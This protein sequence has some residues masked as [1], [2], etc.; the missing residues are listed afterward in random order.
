MRIAVILAVVL[1]PA[2]SGCFADHGP[3][4]S[5]RDCPD[6][7]PLQNGFRV[8]VPATVGEGQ[9]EASTR[10]L[11]VRMSDGTPQTDLE[12]KVGDDQVA[13][14]PVPEPGHYWFSLYVTEPQDR[15]CAH[16]LEGEGNHTGPGVVTVTLRHDGVSLCA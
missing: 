6:S 14:F 5:D 9:N 12:R 15:Y 11:C 8:E 13:W 1:L 10:G 2:L 16:A 3:V 4:G 7:T